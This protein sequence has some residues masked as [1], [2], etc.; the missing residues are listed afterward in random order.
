MR[1][2]V[3]LVAVAAGVA[4]SGCTPEES[5]L[6]AQLWITVNQNEGRIKLTD[7]EPDPF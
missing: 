6:P 2:V 4:L 1:N 3:A 5:A 7:V